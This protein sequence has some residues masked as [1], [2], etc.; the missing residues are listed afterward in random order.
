M[1]FSTGALNLSGPGEAFE[2]RPGGTMHA[3][4][5][6]CAE[7]SGGGTGSRLEA[8]AQTSLRSDSSL[9]VKFCAHCVDRKVATSGVDGRRP[10][11]TACSAG[12]PRFS[13]VSAEPGTSRGPSAPVALRRAFAL[14]GTRA[15]LCPRRH[16]T[17]LSC[18]EH[19]PD[20]RL[21]HL[22]EKERHGGRLGF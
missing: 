16:L 22:H 15:P 4:L 19:F 1:P 12:R 17:P 8:V 6:V 2:P 11:R 3:C 13:W 20:A 14:P 10:C 18:A 5:C 7:P 21:H 9:L